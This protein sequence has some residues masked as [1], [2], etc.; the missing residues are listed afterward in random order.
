MKARTIMTMLMAMA[1][2]IALVP[3]AFAATAVPVNHTSGAMLL[4]D[5][6]Y[7]GTGAAAAANEATSTELAVANYSCVSSPAYTDYRGVHAV[8]CPTNGNQLQTPAVM[9]TW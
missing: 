6:T 2:A 5:S 1:L 8:D 7:Q 9:G 3:C 4:A